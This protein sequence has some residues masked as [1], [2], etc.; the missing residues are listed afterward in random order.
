[1]RLIPCRTTRVASAIVLASAFMLILSSS[2]TVTISHAGT[3]NGSVESEDG[4]PHVKNPGTPIEG[5]ATIQLKEQWRR[6]TDDSEEVIFALLDDIAVDKDGNAYVLDSQLCEVQVFSPDGT[7]LR[8]IGRRGEGP[9][10]FSRPRSVF[11]TSD[12]LIAVAQ[13]MPGKIVLLTPEGDAAGN[14]P[15][16]ESDGMMVIQ[17]ASTAGDQLIVHMRTTTMNDNQFVTDATEIVRLNRDGTIAATLARSEHVTDFTR[18]EFNEKTLVPFSAMVGAV[19][20]RAYVCDNFDAYAVR[21]WGT[22]GKLPRVIEREFEP[23][24][25]SKEERDRRGPLIRVQSDDGEMKTALTKS[26]TDRTVLNIF[27][28]ENG[29]IWVLSCRGAYDTADGELCTLD[30]FDADGHF[31]RQVRLMGDGNLDTDAIVIK[32]NRVFVL[33]DRSSARVAAMGAGSESEDD[34]DVA[35]MTVI[36][37]ELPEPPRVEG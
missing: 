11:I 29:S 3:W 16:P 17:G 18:L 33:T 10:E 22:G 14:H 36:C 5:L 32:G 15:L 1:M 20:G 34:D 27:P 4:V 6:G 23:R 13:S 21:A 12:G 30:E 24:V 37:Y 2:P 28:R 25:R 9:G 26:K 8:T 19:D 7:Y 35:P 31:V